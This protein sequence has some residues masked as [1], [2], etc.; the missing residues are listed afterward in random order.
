MPR[1]GFLTGSHAQSRVTPCGLYGMAKPPHVSVTPPATSG[2]NMTRAFRCLSVLALL[3]FLDPPDRVSGQGVAP[4]GK[5]RMVGV[6]RDS[7]GAA[8]EGVTVAIPGSSV[9][10]DVRGAFQ[11]FTMDHDTVTISIRRLGFEPIEALLGAR[12]GLW[13]TVVVQLDPTAQRLSNVDVKGNAPPTR[14]MLAMRSFDER[15]SRGLGTFIT[16]AE[17]V[18]RGSSRLSDLLRTKRGVNVISRGRVRFAAYGGSRGNACI[19]DIWLDGTR[20]RGMEVDELP[21]N[22]VEMM[23]L[24]PNLSTVPVEFQSFGANTT[25]CGIIV[26]WTR[27]PDGR[28]R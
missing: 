26:V 6:V 25:P 5:R 28:S 8:I 3:L 12:N 1:P 19:P 14:A 7:S 2:P 20:N 17:I 27:I 9:L 24:Y 10:T 11:L 13:D 16:R 4:P 23:E 15:K 18:E 22:T 21:P